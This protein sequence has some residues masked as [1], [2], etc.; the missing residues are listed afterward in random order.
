MAQRWGGWYWHLG[1]ASFLGMGGAIAA[2]GNCALAQ[3]TPDGTLGAESSVVKLTNIDGLPTQQID[4]GA[5]RGA[6][7]FHSFEQFSVPTGGAAFFNNALN[8]QNIISRVTGSSVSNIDGLLRANGA[9]NLFLLNPNGIIFGPNAWLNIGGSFLGSTASSLNFADGTQFSATAHPTTPLLTVSVPIGLQYGGTAGSIRNQSRVLGLQVQPGETLALLGGDVEL[10]GGGLLAPGGRVELGGV[11]GPGTVGLAVDNFTLSYPEGVQRADVSLTNQAIVS[12]SAGGG[13]SIAVNARNL[14]ILRKSVFLAGINSG[15]GSVDSQAGD[16]TLN[17]TGTITIAGIN[18]ELRSAIY[19]NV[20]SGAVGNGGNINIL[21]RSLFV[22]NAY[23][24]AT[25]SGQ[26]NGGNILIQASDSVSVVNSSIST[27]MNSE[28]V[29]KGGNIDILAG[30]LS[31]TDRAQLSASTSGWGDAGSVLIQARDSV[32]LVNSSIFSGVDSEAVGKG[33]NID[34]LAGSLSLTDGAQ[35]SASTS[36]R[37]DAGSVSVRASDTVYLANSLIFSEV[38][39]QGVGKGG[40]IN[41]QARS[42]SLTNE[43]GLS[44]TTFGQGDAGNVLIKASDSVSLVHSAIFSGNIFG[45]HVDVAKGAEPEVA[46]GNGGDINILTGFLSLS[47]NAYLATNTSGQGDAGSVFI[48]ATGSVSLTNKSDI[49]SSVNSGAFIGIN[50][51]PEAVGKGGDINIQ[52]QSLSLNDALLSTLTTEQGNAG[53]VIVQ[54]NDSVS[55]NDSIIASSVGLSGVGNGN[56]GNID[57]QTHDLS[58]NDSIITSSVEPGGVGNGG[59]IDIQTHDLSLTEGSQLLAAVTG[60]RDNLPGGRGQGGNIRI[61]ATATINISGVD[62]DGFSSGLFTSTYLGAIGQ[63]GN[64]DVT[65]RSIRLGNRGTLSAETASGQGGN[66]TLKDLDLLLL[67]HNSQI[68]T[69]AG[70]AQ[71]GGDGGNIDIDTQFL[72]AVP[73]ENSDIT[74][75]AY[76]G[77]GG[78]VRVTNRGIFGT[79]FRFRLTP[80]S[81]ITASSE[82]GVSGVVEINTLDVDP[83]RGLVTLPTELVEASGLIATGCGAGRRQG[84]SKFIITGRGGLP[85]RPG[86][87]HISHYPTG[88]VRSIPSSS[89]S[90]ETK[91]LFSP[92]QR[93]SASAAGIHSLV[94]EAR[95]AS[96]QIVEATGWVIN[97]KGEVV[98]T[99]DAPNAT[100]NIPWMTPATCHGATSHTLPLALSTR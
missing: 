60:K 37:G 16:I 38:N 34:I 33:G 95:S 25:T 21:T 2:S 89:P 18:N 42:L 73:G 43:A 76:E 46:V 58:L 93:T 63:A 98:L 53:D 24:S 45:N 61:N 30:S 32:S 65:A 14:D 12:V 78:N 27:D 44:T 28:A 1:L 29:G 69:T 13:G 39:S 62:A 67:R 81:D 71:G 74:A 85:L 54:T 23:L 11:A 36:G 15:Q 79:Q 91:P 90:I 97:N 4:G 22:N 51:E 99:A 6:N 57:I 77:R 48:R 83:S 10:D 5:T 52:A 19:N 92:L 80:E 68:S 72:I 7:L 20:A 70:T 56:G 40:D 55:L 86:D 35:L 3:I 17:A 31:L 47:D 94:G 100:P 49:N 64:I 84:E 9:A 66:I 88:S 41:I 8:I 82:F 75:N 50:V 87:A 59:N 26:G 96:S